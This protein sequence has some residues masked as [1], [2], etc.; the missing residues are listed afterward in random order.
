MTTALARLTSSSGRTSGGV[1]RRSARRPE[2]AI[3]APRP[4]SEIPSARRGIVIP[5]RGPPSSASLRVVRR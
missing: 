4:S 5:T 2:R 1:V 3:G